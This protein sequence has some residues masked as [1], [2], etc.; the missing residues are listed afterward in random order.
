MLLA[1][2]LTYAY[3]PEVRL[4]FP[5]VRC[6]RGEQWLLLGQSGSGK[7]TLLQLLAG[8]L[9]PAT[10]HVQLGDARYDQLSDSALDR[11][12]GRNVGMVFQRSFFVEAL[13]VTENLE[14]AQSLAGVPKDND[15]I[16]YLLQQLGIGHKAEALPYRLSQGE[17][18]RVAI[19]RALV[20]DP[21]LILAD[22]PTSALDD[23]HAEE[24]IRLLTLT[25]RKAEATLLIV[26]HDNR[27]KGRLPHELHLQNA[28]V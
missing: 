12:R 25:A 20:N 26:T 11:Y 15:R 5:E 17:Q 28:A 21:L 16:K 9:R 18:Q 23:H 24:V 14:L 27:L 3:S 8:L 10:G 7:T 22:E 13:T 19:A 6:G 2:D 4:S 1:Q